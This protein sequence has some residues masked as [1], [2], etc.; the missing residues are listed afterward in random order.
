LVYSCN[1]KVNNSKNNNTME[2]YD[3]E[4]MNKVRESGELSTIVEKGNSWV[5]MT[6]MYESGASYN[7]YSQAPEFYAI[8]KTFYQNGILASKGKFAGRHLKI[9]IWQ[10]YDEKG[11]LIKEVDEDEKFGRIK[12]DQI[13]KFIEKEGWIDL[14]TGRGREE[15][16]FEDSGR[17]Y[18]KKGIFILGFFKKGEN[19]LKYNDYPLWEIII[20]DC[21]ET[22]YYRT[23]YEINGDTGEVLSKKSREVFRTE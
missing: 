9:G 6:C 12:L 15:I 11:H 3:F 8:Q 7:E 10:Y 23:V 17:R 2:K 21:Q 14:T 18:V 4:L 13:L 20:V 16:I 5:F 19:P 22:G 1:W